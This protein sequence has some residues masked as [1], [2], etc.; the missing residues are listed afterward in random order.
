[1]IAPFVIACNPKSGQRRISNIP[2]KD[3]NSDT[4]LSFWRRNGGLAFHHC[5]QWLAIGITE[6]PNLG[7]GWSAALPPVILLK[8][9]FRGLANIQLNEWLCFALQKI[10]RPRALWP[11]GIFW[12][13]W[14][15]LSFDQRRAQ[16][17]SRQVAFLFLN[18]NCGPVIVAQ[19]CAKGDGE[20]NSCLRR[21]HPD[22]LPTRHDMGV[23]QDLA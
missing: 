15:K 3:Q 11:G 2:S 7:S 9:D 21:P 8:E 14:I 23:A 13:T 10:F 20:I 5:L 17:T 6:P 4:K 1:M 12:F 19:G 22:R 16:D 18:E